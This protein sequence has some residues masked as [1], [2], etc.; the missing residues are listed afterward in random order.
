MSNESDSDDI[1]MGNGDDAPSEEPVETDFKSMGID[2]DSKKPD[3][4]EENDEDYG[5]QLCL[6]AGDR[7]EYMKKSKEDNCCMCM[8]LRTGI[9]VISV[10]L[11]VILLID[12]GLFTPWDQKKGYWVAWYWWINRIWMDTRIIHCGN[13]WCAWDGSF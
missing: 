2:G 9:L 5:D 13:P 3:L 7:I 11:P 8:D 10:M 6:I 12:M 4:N 1:E